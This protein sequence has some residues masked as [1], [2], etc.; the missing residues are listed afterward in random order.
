MATSTITKTDPS[1]L[2][3]AILTTTEEHIIPL[4]RQGVTSGCK[5]FGAAILRRADLQPH[6]VATNNE[7]V[8]PLLHG[9]INCIQEFFTKPGGLGGEGGRQRE[10]ADVPRPETKDCIFFATHEPC[11]LC[12]SGITWA[13]FRE[14]YYLFTYEDSRDLFAIPYDIDILQEVFRVRAEG[15][16]DE[17]LGG[18]ALYNRRNKF[19]CA[20]SL[21]E[22][23]EQVE[24]G[25]ERERWRG[26]IARVKGLYGELSDTYQE[27]K[28]KGVETASVWK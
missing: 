15:E 3:R 19:F 2:L 12:L 1:A 21:A 20:G 28:S 9:E 27:G 7:R 22:L 8:S 5:L 24:D 14:F 18:R 26:E 25:A 13:G 10:S 17:A 11:S 16:T 23:V 4:T 6:T